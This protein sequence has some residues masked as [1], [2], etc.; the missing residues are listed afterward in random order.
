MRKPNT[1][2]LP[3]FVIATVMVV[4][5]MVVGAGP[6]PR[7]KPGSPTDVAARLKPGSPTGV[8][9][10]AES[11]TSVG[12]PV[13]RPVA[14]R[15]ILQRAGQW[16]RQ[17][18]DDSVFV[19]A[20]E[21][22]EQEYRVRTGRSWKIERRELLSEIVWVR[23]PADEARRGFPWVQFRDVV[24]V[25]RQPLPEHRGRL[26]RLFKD[27]SPSSYA[28]ARALIEQSARYNIGPFV[29]EINVPSFALFFLY[30]P[31]QS[32]VRFR[33][34]GD[35]VIADFRAVAVAYRERSRPTMIRSVE[36]EDRPASGTVWIDAPSGR[37]LKTDL[38]V[39][40]DRRWVTDTEV[41]YGEDARLH[42]WVPLEMRERHHRGTAEY[43]DATA[44]YGNFRRFETSARMV[45][46]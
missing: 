3:V 36:R 4:S 10:K 28:E 32:R 39:A 19:V 29:R 24:E 6:A 45:P 9:L 27:V 40:T 12:P 8:G 26:E 16:V 44:R 13:F 43:I 11:V 46:R 15:D 14:L 34:T 17:F 7:L 30:P 31:N 22:Y 21:R 38:R 18:A 33:L 37:V 35:E 23:T 5:A 25:D 41:T 42:I 1:R 2:P 20:D